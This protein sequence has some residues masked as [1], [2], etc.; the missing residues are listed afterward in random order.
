MTG[1]YYAIKETSTN[2]IVDEGVIR[3]SEDTIYPGQ[4][5]GIDALPSECEAHHFEAKGYSIEI[6]SFSITRD[7]VKKYHTT[8]D[9]MD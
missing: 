5:T 2:E 3:H 4:N 6:C 1:T 9:R 8:G 7:I